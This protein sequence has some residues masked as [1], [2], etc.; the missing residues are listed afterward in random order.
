MAEWRGGPPPARSHRS[1]PLPTA[2]QRQWREEAPSRKKPSARPSTRPPLQ[3][4]ADRNSAPPPPR[5]PSRATR[6]AAAAAFPPAAPP[7]HLS[8]PSAPSTLPIWSGDALGGGGVGPR[9]GWGRGVG[10][11]S[12]WVHARI[13][14]PLRA[15]GAASNEPT[16]LAPSSCPARCSHG[17]PA[18]VGGPGGGG[19]RGRPTGTA[20]A[21]SRASRG[22]GVAVPPPCGAVCAQ[23]SSPSP[24][25]RP[26]PPL[27]TAH[28]PTP[29]LPP[30]RRPSSPP[31]PPGA[32]ASFS[33][34]PSTTV[35]P[36]V[37]LPGST[38]PR[39]PHPS[40]LGHARGAPPPL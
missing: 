9:R 37:P 8:L 30:V 16:G 21:A 14:T 33:P 26:A 36:P 5:P 12:L 17:G 18:M 1:R 29:C 20:A 4:P 34:A 7:P 23:R 15:N 31:T 35:P 11:C 40:A 38:T 13:P 28:A 22:S 19:G 3:P 27:P 2:P 32:R 10:A 39:P 25:P 24:H 6:S